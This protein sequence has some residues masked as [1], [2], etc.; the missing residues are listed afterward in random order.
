MPLP[1][2][3][4][5]SGRPVDLPE[6]GFAVK[7]GIGLPNQ[8][9]DVEPTVIPQWARLAEEAGVSTLGTVGRIASP[10]VMAPVALAGA[11]AVTSRIGLISTVML[12]GVWPPALI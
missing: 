4:L 9:R 5:R 8:V 11:A 6:E 1:G 3:P 10:G 12:T 2:P 7:I